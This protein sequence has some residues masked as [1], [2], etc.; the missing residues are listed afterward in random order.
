MQSMNKDK[1]PYKILQVLKDGQFHSG[2]AL[3]YTLEMTRSAIWK[4]VKQLTS[5]YHLEIE[6]ISGRGYRIKGGLNLLDKNEI[7]RNT[8]A[9]LREQLQISLLDQVESTNDYL[10]DDVR[11]ETRCGLPYHIAIA[12]QQTQGRGRRGHQWHS[13][14]GHNIYFSLAWC[15]NKDP[16]EMSGLSLAAAVAVIRTLKQLGVEGLGVKWPNDIYYHNQKLAGVLIDLVG[17]SYGRTTAI[18]GIGINTYLSE[19]AASVIDQPWTSLHD[20][21]GQFIDRNYIIALLCQHVIAM[22]NQFNQDH[23]EPFIDEWNQHDCFKGKKVIL[24]NGTQHIHGTMQGI[25]KKGELLLEDE[26][27]TIKKYSSGELSMRESK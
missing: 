7:A 12:E 8:P 5:H 14:Y 25:S 11:S 21:L 3:G 17:E 15:C 20:I 9:P 26:H 18:I 19:K 2:E 24:T 27:A 23:L 13:P 4:G 1:T 6:S 22:I 16:I 10:L